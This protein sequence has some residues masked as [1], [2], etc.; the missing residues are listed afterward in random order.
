MSIVTSSATIVWLTLPRGMRVGTDGQRI[1]DLSA[2]VSPRLFGTTTGEDLLSSLMV[3]PVSL[4]SA[5]ACP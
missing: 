1:L 2:L 5:P 4:P 3:S